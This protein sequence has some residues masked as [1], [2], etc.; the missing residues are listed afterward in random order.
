MSRKIASI[1]LC[2]YNGAKYIGE[3]LASL[4]RQTRLPDELI[5]CDDRSMDETVALLKV[6]AADAPF[7][8]TIEINKERLGPAANFAKAAGL[9]HGDIVLFCDQ[10]DI[11]HDDKVAVQLRAVAAAERQA[12]PNIPI[13]VHGDL[14]VVDEN[15]T[16]LHPSFMRLMHPHLDRFNMAYL[17]GDNVAVGCATAVNRALL[18]IALPLPEQALMHDWWFAQCAIGCGRIVYIDRPLMQYRQ[19]QAN[20][21][22]AAPWLRRVSQML[23]APRRQWAE[24]LESLR[25]AVAQARALEERLAARSCE[26][27]SGCQA[28]ADYAALLDAGITAR[29]RHTF[30][31]GYGRSGRLGI[32]WFLTKAIFA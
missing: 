18:D 9:C 24:K 29:I 25:A 28:M 30:R 13:L 11:W 1:A 22:G 15:L 10:D 14:E 19:H 2:T 8:V 23:S 21:I 6:F 31:H 5:V 4:S 17:L 7:P 12:R 16:P 32:L 27:K 26:T 20:Q 3:Q